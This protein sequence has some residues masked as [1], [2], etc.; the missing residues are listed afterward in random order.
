MLNFWTQN[1]KPWLAPDTVQKRMRALDHHVAQH[2]FS[3]SDEQKNN[4][5]HALNQA[6]SFAP[7]S[8]LFAPR[9]LA[10]ASQQAPQRIS[11]WPHLNR[12]TLPL[13]PRLGLCPPKLMQHLQHHFSQHSA[14]WR[15]WLL[16]R[17]EIHGP[18]AGWQKST[19]TWHFRATEPLSVFVAAWHVL[20]DAR[21]LNALLRLGDKLLSKPITSFNPQ[22][23]AE[24]LG[25]LSCR[26]V[27]LKHLESHLEATPAAN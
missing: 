2:F 13:P 7:K 14:V 15:E 4:C 23:Q 20:A 21:Y 18:Q 22:E 26:E 17:V 11:T 6:L 12:L 19:Q 9:S 25:G 16:C 24:L 27:I 8:H 10:L 5:L 3:L 1:L